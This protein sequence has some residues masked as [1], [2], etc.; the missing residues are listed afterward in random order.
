MTFSF[1][2]IKNIF[3]AKQR[4]IVFCLY[5]FL[6]IFLF[7]SCFYRPFAY[8]ALSTL[9]LLYIVGNTNDILCAFLF[10][11]PFQLIT[12]LGPIQKITMIFL[13]GI[14]LLI[15]LIKKERKLHIPQLVL[16]ISF[17]VYISVPFYRSVTISSLYIYYVVIALIYLVFELK[18]EI[19]ITELVKAYCIGIIISSLMSLFRPISSYLNSILFIPAGEYTRLASL[20]ENPNY[21]VRGTL[22]VL[23]MLLVLKYYKK[24]GNIGFTLLFFPTFIFSYLTISRNFILSFLIALAIF[25]V[26]YLIKYKN[27]AIK[28]L[29]I[30]TLSL[31]FV[32][33]IF[34]PVTKAYLFRFENSPELTSSMLVEDV[35]SNKTTITNSIS[36][37]YLFLSDYIEG[38]DEWWEAV[39]T[40]KIKYDP[41]RIGIWKLN[42]KDWSLSWISV[43]FGKGI[44]AP[45]VGQMHAHNIFIEELRHLGLVGFSLLIA[46]IVST[47]VG[48]VKL[49]KLLPFTIFI[50]PILF[51]DSFEALL[52]LSL[53]LIIFAILFYNYL[54]KEEQKDK[55]VKRV[56]HYS[57]F[58]NNDEAETYVINLIENVDRTKNHFDIIIRSDENISDSLLKEL[59]DANVKVTFLGKGHVKQILNGVMFLA[60]NGKNYDVMHVNATSGSVGIFAYLGKDI[61]VIKNV[62][63]YSNVEET[64]KKNNVI[65]K[66]GVFLAKNFSDELAASSK[67]AADFMFGEKYCKK[68]EIVILDNPMDIENLKLNK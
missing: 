16:A 32:C 59:N 14:R 65:D 40:G 1:E 39:K 37:G 47:F 42:L 19:D 28:F 66:I 43:L 13:L 53:T 60:K 6:T 23:C 45:Q 11:Y 27:K 41:G 20:T 50:L 30:F 64:D 3:K 62:V 63:F 44:G 2:N 61:G 68:H 9:V 57:S 17:V 58:S 22:P 55:S 4:L 67:S 48:K 18:D 15:G 51:F 54:E 52:N 36:R 33:G 35:S 12:V 56:L 38:S 5:V 8:L 49:K 24:I 21:F 26:M 7:I 25:V 29:L 34:F 46:F 31:T 10:Y